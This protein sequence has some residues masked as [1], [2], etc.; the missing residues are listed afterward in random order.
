VS[1]VGRQINKSIKPSSVFSR[2]C[3]LGLDR[4]SLLAEAGRA[5]AAAARCAVEKRV[6]VQ[7]QRDG[8]DAG[9]GAMRA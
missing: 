8:G 9:F 1:I 2:G 3:R 5:R 6:A 7:R 4:H